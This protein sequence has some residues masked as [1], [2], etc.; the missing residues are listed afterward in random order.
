[1]CLPRRARAAAREP[2]ASIE[3]GVAPTGLVL[4]LPLTIFI[5]IIVLSFF[6]LDFVE[7]F[8]PGGVVVPVLGG[9]LR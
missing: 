2:L 7:L 3:E 9:G 4:P 5:A 6:L 8:L 1:M